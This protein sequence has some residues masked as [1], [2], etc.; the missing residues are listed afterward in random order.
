MNFSELKRNVVE[1]IGA[2]VFTD[3]LKDACLGYHS[4]DALMLLDEIANNPVED[5]EIAA[6][7]VKIIHPLLPPSLREQGE[8]KE[9]IAALLP[10]YVAPVA[11]SLGREA[12]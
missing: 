9:A 6:I 8:V 7:A 11:L 1:Q 3:A 12:I 5:N 2:D 10:D 4:D